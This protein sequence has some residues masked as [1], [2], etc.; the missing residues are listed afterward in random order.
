MPSSH[1]TLGDLITAGYKLYAHHAQLNPPCSHSS[2]LDLNALTA[3]LGPDFDIVERHAE[4]LASLRCSKC[5][6][7]GNMSI[8]RTPPEWKG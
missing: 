8:V 3:K 2:E 1:D 7:K 4:L 5:K 6:H